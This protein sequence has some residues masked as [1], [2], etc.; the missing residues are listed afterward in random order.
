MLQLARQYVPFE[1]HVHL[2]DLVNT[3]IGTCPESPAK[4][5]FIW[6]SKFALNFTQFRPFVDS[7]QKL[8]IKLLLEP[9]TSHYNQTTP[10]PH[11][12]CVIPEKKYTK[13][14]IHT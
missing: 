11:V 4:T 5:P 13:C 3:N 12:Q 9:T 7:I 8:Q 2:A 14:A 1:P 6:N 10:Y